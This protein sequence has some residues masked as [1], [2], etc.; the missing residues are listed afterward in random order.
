M[1]KNKHLTDA[2]RLQIEQWLKDRVHISQIAQKLNK[3]KSTVSREIRSRAIT[4]DKYAPYRI[5][6]RCINRNDCQ[7]RYLCDNKPNCT[8]R[9]S[10]CSLCN[11]LCEDYQEQPC[12]KLYD[13][14]YVCN[15]CMDEHQCVLRKKYY[16]HR[17]AH[18]A[19]REMLVESRVG[20][21]ITENELLALDEIVS[22][23]VM[24]GQSIHH[25][26]T[27]NPDQFEVSEK[28]IY[29][30][31]SGGL[32]KARNID[33]PRVCR[34]KPRK[35]KPVEHKVDSGCR[36]GRT[37]AD[38]LSF[39]ETSGASVVEM[40]SVIGRI[41]GKVLLTMM[42][43][44]CDLMLAFIRDR[45]TSQSVIDVFNHIDET[46]GRET[47]S[48]LL[49]VCLADNGSEFS[50]P[51]ALEYDE[52]GNSR[53]RLF[54]CD[55]FAAFQKPNVELNHEFIRKILPKGVSFDNLEQS[56]ISLM[57]SHINSYSREKLNDKTP[58]DMFGF[59]YG[60]DV[61]EKLGIYRIPA[62]EILLKP[63]LLKK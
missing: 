35:S 22:P 60:Y 24:R 28:S 46:L 36:I 9:C 18:E 39:V 50:N 21:N 54:Y 3:N 61:L 2:E 63:S 38:F 37:Y 29:R 26:V 19:Y 44:S 1:P 8:K 7:K 56:D 10:L 59:I 12:Y 6:N 25:I 13:P 45:N 4:S 16:L 31:V 11:D 49:T 33:M 55:P 14:P 43:K 5:H 27:H 20:A 51:K 40:D 58:F 48:R 30:Y 47:F 62:N 41:G 32:L 52:Q 34:I 23:L 15:G 42:F 57:M 53:T 17:K